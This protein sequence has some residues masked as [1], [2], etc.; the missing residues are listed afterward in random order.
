MKQPSEK[1]LNA[2]Y[3]AIAKY[4]EEA[5]GKAIVLGGVSIA[6]NKNDDREMAYSIVVDIMGVVPPKL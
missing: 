5:G 3:R 1:T 4:I 2:M 6:Q